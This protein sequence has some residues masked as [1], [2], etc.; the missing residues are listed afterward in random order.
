MLEKNNIFVGFCDICYNDD[1]YIKKINKCRC[2][3]NICLECVINICYSLK[4]DSLFLFYDLAF[5]CPMCRKYIY[6][7]DY[8][9]FVC[10][11]EN[12][13]LEKEIFIYINFFL[14]T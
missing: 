11:F 2:N 3:I 9:V 12:D 6:C 10:D 4:T 8:F 14:F 5:I 7:S 13:K 1:Q